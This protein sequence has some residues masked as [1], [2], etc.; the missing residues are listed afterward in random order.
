MIIKKIFLFICDVDT[1]WNS[2]TNSGSRSRCT[3]STWPNCRCASYG[4]SGRKTTA[5]TWNRPPKA[6][7]CS[8][9][10]ST[11]PLPNRRPGSRTSAR[12]CATSPSSCQRWVRSCP[13]VS[14]TR[15][16]RGWTGVA[17][18]RPSQ[19]DQILVFV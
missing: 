12:I 9:P 16:D 18:C 1:I 8:I 7:W 10:P 17:R 19:L 14:S 5:T 4:A 11:W 2:S 3:P 6:H 15:S 13:T